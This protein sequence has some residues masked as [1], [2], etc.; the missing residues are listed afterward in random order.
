M[1]WQISGV[2]GREQVIAEL[3]DGPGSP[4]LSLTCTCCAGAY[5][6][7]DKQIN[8]ERCR[9]GWWCPRT[10]DPRIMWFDSASDV[11]RIM[12]V[13]ASAYVALVAVLRV[14]G[15]RTL[16][17]LNAF[18]FVVTV[19]LGSL[20]ATILLS[21]SVSLVDGVVALC[22]LVGLQAVVAVVSTRVP[23]VARLV[24][25]EPA[26][27]VVDGVMQEDVMR[28]ERVHPEEVRQA[29]RLSGR[30]GLEQVAVVVLETDGRL[31][32]IPSPSL[33][34]GDALAEIPG[35]DAEH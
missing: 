22:L 23:V 8:P 26:L 10:E 32:V 34:S 35:W 15:K 3:K 17:K 33:G 4:R 18:D 12:V 31:S 7:Q 9:D 25:S 29:V 2:A 19:A 14:A 30:G 16:S 24:K 11:I 27:L 6:L 28:S 5:M 13:G 20:L 21:T 1:N